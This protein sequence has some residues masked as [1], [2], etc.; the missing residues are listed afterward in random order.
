MTT[1][2]FRP[3]DVI[4]T[5][6]QEGYWGC[7]IV[8]ASADGTTSSHPRIHVG[9]TP[10]I[11]RH[12]YGWS[13]LD[14]SRL[15]IL[16]FTRN[17]RMPSGEYGSRSETCIGI[18]TALARGEV[19]VIGEVDPRKIYTLPLDATVGNATAGHFP[20]CG[21]LTKAVGQEAV[22]AWRRIHD[23]EGLARDTE[24]SRKRFEEMEARR[25][26][27]DSRSSRKDA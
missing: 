19:R 20:L 9:I 17:I 7:A 12:A 18:Y 5:E 16:S 27:R 22:I 23:A 3:G 11:F 8:L 4:Q 13:E 2:E 1:S 24:D 26:S 15:S 10:L 21:P 6:P 14:A 25:L